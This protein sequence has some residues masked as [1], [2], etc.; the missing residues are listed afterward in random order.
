MGK[1]TVSHRYNL[2]P[3][4]RSNPGG[5]G[6]ELVVQDLPERKGNAF[7]WIDK[8][9]FPEKRKKTLLSVGNAHIAGN[10]HHKFF[11]SAVFVGDDAI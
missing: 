2:L 11:C 1:L 5:I 10:F 4:L 8:I 7:F 6:R 3:L 9:F